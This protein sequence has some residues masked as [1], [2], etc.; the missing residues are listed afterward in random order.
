LSANSSVE[1]CFV[2]IGSSHPTS[3]CVTEKLKNLVQ[4]CLNTLHPL[5]VRHFP[6]RGGLQLLAGKYLQ[7]Y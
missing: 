2:N 6:I 3:V 7:I 4:H 1:I 5:L